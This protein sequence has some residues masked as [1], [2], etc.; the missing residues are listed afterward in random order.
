MSLFKSQRFFSWCSL[1]V[2]TFALSIMALSQGTATIRGTVFDASRAAIPG[3]DVV[4]TN[5][6]TNFTRRTVTSAEGIFSIS[7]LGGG[8]YRVTVEN[9]GFK[10]YVGTLTLQTGQ[11]AVVDATL[12]L[13]SVDTVVEVSGAAP[14]I[15]PESSEVGNVK[16][17]TQIRNLPLNGRD[18]TSLFSLT[19]GVEGGANPRVNGMKVG[20]TEMLLDGVSIV[21][22]F[23]G[24]M[25]R[26]QPGLDSV[27]EFRIETAGSQAQYSRPATVSLVTK[28][29]TNEVHG[30]AFFTH[31]NNGGGLRARQRQDGNDA[32]KLIRNEYG[33][34]AGGPVFLPKFYDG[35]NRTFWF[36]AYEGLKQREQQFYRQPV[37]TADMWAGNFD[38]I[39]DAQG[40]KTN[41]YDPLTTNALGVRQQFPNNQI[42]TNRLSPFYQKMRS[43]TPLP[44]NNINPYIAENFEAVYPNVSD[45]YKFTGRGDHRFSDN[46]LLMGRFTVSDRAGSTSGGRYGAPPLG[47]EDAYGSRRQNSRLYSISLQE[48]HIFTPTLLNEFTVGL[49]RNTNSQGTLADNKAWANELGLPNPFGALGWP[50]I[51]GDGPFYWDNDNRQDQ[52]LTGYVLE[53]NLTWVTGQHTFKMG[54]KLRF[55]QNNVRELQQAQGANGFESAWTSLYDPSGDQA[56]PFTGDGMATMALGLP[57][58]LS[59]QNNRGYFYFRQQ[60]TGLYFQDTWKVSNRLTLDLG[61]RWDRWSPYSEKQNRFVQVDTQTVGSL[62]QVVT[63]GNHKME[64]LPGIPKSQLD[65]WAL[66]GLTW[67]TADS[68]GLPTN[69]VRA[70]NNNFGPRI[71]LAYKL[72]DHTV[73]HA[74]YGEYFWTMPLSQI[75]QAMRLTPPLNL[76]YENQ[77]AN[78]DGTDTYG[79]R[80]TPSSNDFVGQVQVDTNGIVPLPSNAQQGLTMDGRNWKDGRAQKFHF[81]FEHQFMADSAVRLSYLGDRGRDLEQRYSLNQRESEFNYVTRTGLNPPGNRDLMRDNKDW[82]LFAVNRTGYSN[83]H[84]FQ[85]EYEKRYSHGFLS[86]FFYT[87]TRSLTTSDS[88]GFT[89]GNGNINATG[90]GIAQVPQ[91][92]QV[93]GAPQNS[94][95]DL[96]RLVYYNSGAIPEHRVRWNGVL[97]LPFGKGR[98][99]FGNASGLVNSIVGGWQL[100]GIGDWRSGNWLSV[101][102]SRYLFGDPTLSADERL[103]LNFGGRPQRLWFK[104]DFD[105]TKATGVDAAKLQNLIPVDRSKRVLTQVGPLLDNRVPVQLKDGST[106][107]TTITDG[108]NWNARNFMKGPGAWNADLTLGKS[109]AIT[110]QVNLQFAADFFNA[111]NSPMDVNPNAITGLQDLSQQ[112]N[113][114][115]TIQLR[116]R[117]SW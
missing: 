22:R 16:D 94:Y 44:T 5:L 115:R 12:E 87:F 18:I 51:Y 64:D 41:I 59:N 19:A 61:V 58:Y 60:E 29:G 86:Q 66:R 40:R 65:S 91:A 72:T 6:D 89:S 99:I 93:L 63:P 8:P 76:R 46:D 69:L 32:A 9:P 95:D 110:E 107:L 92:N 52:N 71:G 31:R 98:A 97:D 113:G 49:Q 74:S 7:S 14:I 67:T 79:V 82:N 117:I 24:G 48:T 90:T 11:T 30:S 50:T 56:V 70:D 3:A 21:D 111:F 112:S 42:P 62:F 35:R 10:Q 104:G 1:A 23:G 36:A 78:Q 81:T 80:T 25:S 100:T 2:A 4:V 20:A 106:R 84:S 33:L 116:G 108:V 28:S 73:L 15:N 37:P 38:N 45:V 53:D 26:V 101:D 83:T 103:L 54:G 102:A 43:V 39:I 105:V 47:M 13:G 68:V 55:E 34:S 57:T 109:F 114:P 88:D 75:L 17:A 77:V 96:L 85:A 27:N